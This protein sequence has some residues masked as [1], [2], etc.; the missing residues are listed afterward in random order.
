MEIS[1]ADWSLFKA[2][3]PQWQEAYMDRLNQEYLSILSS[4]LS[5]SDKFWAI[6]QRISQDK[7][8]TGVQLQLRRSEM[9]WHLIGLIHEGAITRED[10]SDFSED[11]QAG[12]DFLLTGGQETPATGEDA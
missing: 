6:E 11:L 9:L 1:K 2:K 10:C 4:D 7:R 8:R 12:I 3:V 5:P